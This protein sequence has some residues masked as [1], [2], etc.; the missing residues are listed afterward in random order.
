MLL[1]EKTKTI[2]NNI[3]VFP[4]PCCY[5]LQKENHER[6]QHDKTRLNNKEQKNVELIIQ[7]MKEWASVAM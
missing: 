6:K 7:H 5:S 2:I 1:L 4:F 3:S